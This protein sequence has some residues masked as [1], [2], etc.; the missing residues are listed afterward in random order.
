MKK[1]INRVMSSLRSRWGQPVRS[2][3]TGPRC[4]VGGCDRLPVLVVAAIK[5]SD[6]SMCLEHARGWVDS[7]TCHD[8][9]RHN[10]PMNLAPLHRWATPDAARQPVLPQSI[11]TAAR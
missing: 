8:L 7:A 6:V 3:S 5:G 2:K 1:K 4:R 9:S 11:A 10:Q